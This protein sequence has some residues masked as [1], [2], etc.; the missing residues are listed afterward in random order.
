MVDAAALRACIE[1]QRCPWCGRAGLRSLANHT[2]RAHQIYARELR[3]LAG[4]PPDA[5][6]CSP[7]LSER[8]RE[9]TREHDTL[10]RLQ[11][12]EV[13]RAAAQSREAGYSVE[14]RRRRVDHLGAVRAQARE[15]SRVSLRAEQRDPELAAARGLNRS[16]ARRTLRP[17]AECEVCGAWFCSVTPVGQAYRQRKTCSDACFREAL[18]RLRRR[19]WIDRMLET[20]G[21]GQSV[22][23]DESSRVLVGHHSD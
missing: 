20:L 22:A 1:A 17:G 13:V 15:A 21:F 8:H 6:L 2:V 11:R 4:L 18:S 5:P 23:A 19:D 10:E 14:Q 7:E 3:E 12:P 9:L 16:Q